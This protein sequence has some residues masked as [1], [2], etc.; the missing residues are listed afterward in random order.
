M[1]GRREA[2]KPGALDALANA[3]MRTVNTVSV[4]I[5]AVPEVGGWEDVPRALSAAQDVAENE[6]YPQVQLGD[7]RGGAG[8]VR[9]ARSDGR[10]SRTSCGPGRGER[11][12]RPSPVG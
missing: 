1:G 2:R 6:R 9:S 3:R 8:G 12:V 5:N 4:D 7:E 11:T 10:D